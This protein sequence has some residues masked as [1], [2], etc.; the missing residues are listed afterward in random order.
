M[1]LGGCQIISVMLLFA[2]CSCV[3]MQKQFDQPRQIE[4]FGTETNILQRGDVP[5]DTVSIE[6]FNVRITPETEQYIDD[7]WQETDEQIIPASVRLNLFR[8]GIRVGIQGSQIS[9]TL[10]KLINVTGTPEMPRYIN[11][12]REF[13]VSEMTREL[14]VTKQFQHVFPGTRVVLKPF[15][16]PLYELSLFDRESSQIWGK[17]YTNAL[18]LFALTTNP[19]SDGKVRFEVVPELEYGLPETKMYSRQGI[20]FTETGKPRRIFEQL[21]IK[22]DL[23]VGNWLILGP[24]SI[25]CQGV[26]RCF[27][28]RGEEQKEQK[29]VAIRLTNLK[30]PTPTNNQK[31]HIEYQP[32]ERK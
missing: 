8:N 2:V 14:T 27:F 25:N 10:S 9:S 20:M 32:P 28:V 12:M 17:T 23:L 1:K 16:S 26:G 19:Q 6:I 31:T 7:L 18:G 3:P 21:A 11:G 13:D 22:A 15:E 4:H 30:K 5:I 29:I 24:T